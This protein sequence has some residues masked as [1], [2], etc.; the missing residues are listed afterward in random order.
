[1]KGT[2]TTKETTS[3]RRRT[4]DRAEPKNLTTTPAPSN[5]T[6]QTETAITDVDRAR[7]RRIAAL[8]SDPNTP[9]E[10]RERLSDALFD[11]TN[12][13]HVCINHPEIVALAYG[14]A[15]EQFAY[16]VKTR[17]LAAQSHAHLIAEIDAHPDPT[18]AGVSP[19]AARII[20]SL[21]DEAHREADR[22]AYGL[23]SHVYSEP[24]EA[25]EAIAD[26]F[27]QV[28]EYDRDNG[29][30]FPQGCLRSLADA[31]AG[32]LLQLYTAHVAEGRGFTRAASAEKGGVK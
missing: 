1:M 9:E 5:L 3:K 15:C 23:A 18:P 12:Q 8:L 11:F 19:T 27:R 29:F 24:I 7:A 28:A 2:T 30:I 6:T 26:T 17:D 21:C 22:L 20:Q 31:L 32:I 13:A 14:L 16:F 4:G 10:T 25:A